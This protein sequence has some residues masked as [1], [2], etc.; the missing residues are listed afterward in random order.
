MEMREVDG[1][2]GFD[3]PWHSEEAA[4]LAMC[5]LAGLSYLHDEGEEAGCIGDGPKRI[6]AAHRADRPDAKSRVEAY[7]Q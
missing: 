3:V 4:E 7:C 2:L 6:G 5:N 1:I